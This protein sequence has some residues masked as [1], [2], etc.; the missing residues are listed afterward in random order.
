V[1]EAIQ[2]A[3]EH[4]LRLNQPTP[5]HS[6]KD[7]DKKGRGER[8]ERE[9]SVFFLPVANFQQ[10]SWKL[11]ILT[12]PEPYGYETQNAR[13]RTRL[14]GAAFLWLAASWL[15]GFGHMELGLLSRLAHA[16]I[17]LQSLLRS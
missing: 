7:K 17:F 4:T 1:W 14:L 16:S 13:S 8:R 12:A 5:S 9:T 3:K 15:K 10:T 11:E 2:A 6:D